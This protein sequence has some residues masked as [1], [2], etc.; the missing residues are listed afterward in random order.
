MG[1]NAQDRLPSSSMWLKAYPVSGA[2]V[3]FAYYGEGTEYKVTW[4]MDVAWNSSGNVRR[5]Y[6]YIGNALN[7]GRISFQPSD[8]VGEDLKLSNSQQRSLRSRCNNIKISGV[9]NVIINCDHEALNSENYYGKPENW[10]RMIKASVL[11]A[12]SQGLNVTSILPFNEPDYTEWGEGSQ[13]DFKEIARLIKEDPDLEGIRVC[14]G[15]T[16]NCD[17]ALNWYNYMKPYIDEGNTHE[18]AGSFNNYALFFQQVRKDGNHATAD[19]M[20]NTME[21]FIAVHYGLQTGIWWGYDGVARGDFCKAAYGGHELGYG[22][23]RSAWA[24]GC[25][26]RLPSGAVEA[27][28]GV[29]ERQANKNW[30]DI[31]STD[32][33]VYYDGYGPVRLYQQFLPGD[34]VY[35]STNQKNA[36]KVIHIHSGEDVPLD[37]LGG[38]YII[39]NKSTNR[40]MR[41]ASNENRAAVQQGIRQGYA[42]ERWRISPT[43]HLKGGDFSYHYIFNT[44]AGMYLNN[45]N[46]SLTAN[47]TYIIYNAGGS[48]NEQFVME[49]AGNGFY[50]IRNHL[51]GLYLEANGDTNIRQAAFT[52]RD[53]QQWRF[54]PV[55]AQCEQDPPAAP[56]G[57]KTEGRTASVLLSWDAN[58]ESDI[59]GYMI[60]RAYDKDGETI[61]QTIGRNIMGT[62]FLDNN[63][64]PGKTYKYRIKAVDLSGNRSEPSQEAEGVTNGEKALIAHYEFDENILD[65]SENQFDCVTYKD[66][67]YSTIA[68]LV[69]SGT[70]SISLDGSK[71]YLLLSNSVGCL[72]EMTISFWVYN[73]DV[74]RKMA[75]VFDFGSDADHCMYFT[76][77]NGTNTR[78]VI[79]KDDVEQVLATT[80]LSSGWKYVSV[81]FDKSQVKLYINGEEVASEDIS[82]RPSDINPAM[83]FIG[84]SQSVSDPLFKGRLDDFRIYNYALSPEEIRLDMNGGVPDAIN[85]LDA[86]DNAVV[87]STE[88]FTLSGERTT[89]PENGIFIM[90]Q[91]CND[92]S[93]RVKKVIVR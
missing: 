17:K 46:N 6:N 24:A 39:M 82:I 73:G 79:K 84:R 48:D 32:C 38:D 28:V 15:N 44:T 61:W 36:D 53:V 92:G 4:G 63:C 35:G 65:D 77:Y 47:G 74:A 23:N 34:G 86:D 75:K 81:T 50:Y 7:S 57:L 62:E 25:V 2:K 10:Y 20:H 13:A 43:S 5:G 91:R 49:Y 72:N 56:T 9:T 59:N 26:Y 69:K 8:S 64:I 11:Y 66:V 21:A 87:I 76:I 55:N 68:Q 71:D 19:E 37:T 70:S 31:V 33:D 42:I 1:M 14:G 89:R 16:L 88:Y 30:M 78:F 12:K 45:L 3:P 22:E 40:V 41:P 27:F 51:S 85:S 90:K 93:M 60:F 80:K 83:C 54:M 29:S 58:S 52:G 67:S 18:L